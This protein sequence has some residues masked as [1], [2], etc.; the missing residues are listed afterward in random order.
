MLCVCDGC[1]CV[2]GVCDGGGD[3]GDV[4][5]VDCGGWMCWMGGCG[6]NVLC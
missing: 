1:V 4:C 2:M 5:D 3:D 6:V